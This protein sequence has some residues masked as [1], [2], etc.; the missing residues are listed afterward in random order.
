MVLALLIAFPASGRVENNVVKIIKKAEIVFNFE[1]ELKTESKNP[2][3][4]IFT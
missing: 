3:E 1:N 4:I 2:Q